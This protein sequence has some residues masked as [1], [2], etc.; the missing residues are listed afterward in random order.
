[1]DDRRPGDRD[2]AP[3][4]PARSAK[5][6]RR[7]RLGPMRSIAR[8]LLRRGAAPERPPAS[9]PSG[10]YGIASLHRATLEA[11]PD[12]R[13]R[14]NL[15]LPTVAAARTFGGIRTAIDVFE[16]V[17]VHAPEGRIVAAAGAGSGA[18][19]AID[20]Y[21]EEDP[22]PDPGDADGPRTR[23][24]ALLGGRDATLSVRANDVFMATSWTTAE[25]VVRIRRWQVTTFGSAPD[26]FGYVVQDYEPGF[27]ALSAHHLLARDTYARP[28][29]TVGIFNTALLRDFFHETGIRFAL[30]HTFEPRMLP[31]LRAA[32]QRPPAVRSR[33]ILVYGRPTTP[34]NAFPAIIDG[35]RV[36]R[37][38]DPDSDGWTV[39]SMG[40]EHPEI[41]LG[42]GMTLRSVG[43]LDLE[44]YATLLREAAIGVSLMVSPHPSYPPLEMAYLGMLVATNRFANKD[45][46]RW[47]PNIRSVDDL[48]AE[49][50]AAAISEL[51]RR[52]ETDPGSG[53]RAV[54]IRREFTSDEPQFPFAAELAA[55]LEA[56]T[57]A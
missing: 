25:L 43:K 2:Q 56:G 42:R 48:S 19:A 7:G 49:G 6:G 26:A 57:H 9:R 50:V 38:G 33:T 11:S 20:G 44:A 16:A 55:Q 45:L 10:D 40:G 5:G 51:C 21:L 24:V 37:A 35:L 31:P 13:Y 14:L 54:P 22:T 3:P 34:R 36:W 52:F 23:S 28:E 53:D 12:P 32:L 41:D 29:E 4:G 30:E 46:E 17:A 15:V 8:R 18:T 27:Y 39:L 1:V 47:H